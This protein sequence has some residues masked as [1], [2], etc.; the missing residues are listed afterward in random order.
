MNPLG[1]EKRVPVV[2]ALV[3]GNSINATCHVTGVAKHTC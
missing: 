3:E 1:T 2:S